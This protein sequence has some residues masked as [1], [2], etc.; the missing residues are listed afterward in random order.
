MAGLAGD[1]MLAGRTTLTELAALV[2]DA[3]VVISGDTSVA[4]LATAYRPPYRPPSIVLFGPVSPALWG[5]PQRPE[6]VALWRGGSAGDPHGQ[7]ID[8]AL[9]AIDVPEV[10]S[11]MERQLFA[12][13]S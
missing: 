7:D 10:L 13:V 4:H 12:G 1:A 2:A 3:R 11:V 9:L 8:P 5:P 6:H